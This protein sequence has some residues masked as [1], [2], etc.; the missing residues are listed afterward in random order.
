MALRRQA[1]PRRPLPIVSE[2]CAALA[3]GEV[4]LDVPERVQ[5]G[6]L[7]HLIQAPDSYARLT[8]L[9]AP[10][11]KSPR[12]SVLSLIRLSLTHIVKQ[13]R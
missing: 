12:F 11:R 7:M 9:I 10:T 6:R 5:R 2:R 8:H 1:A 3:A 13:V 4:T